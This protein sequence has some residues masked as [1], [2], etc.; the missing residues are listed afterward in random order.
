MHPVITS[1]LFN[2][3]FKALIRLL[4]R[5]SSSIA[6]CITHQS[7]FAPCC[8]YPCGPTGCNSLPP[9]EIPVGLL[10]YPPTL[11]HAPL[12]ACLPLTAL[13]TVGLYIY[14]SPCCT[15]L[16]RPT[17]IHSYPVAAMPTGPFTTNGAADCR[18]TSVHCHLTL[19]I[20]AGLPIS[21]AI[22]P[23]M[24]FQAC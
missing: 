12:Q 21:T 11:L 10:V 1:T 8:V 6:S 18:P 4:H 19:D 24:P 2:F 9:T 22:L 7:I 3:I 13:L 17:I 5:R 16:C 14:T 15:Y 20:S 23:P